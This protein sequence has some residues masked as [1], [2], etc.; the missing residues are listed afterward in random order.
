MAKKKNLSET[1]IIT[2]LIEN[3]Y[4]FQGLNQE[5]LSSFLPPESLTKEKLFSNRPVFTAFLPDENLDSLYIILEGGPVIVRSNPLDR[6][7]SITY[8]GGCFGMRSLPF[9][10]GLASKSFPSLVEA[11]KTTYITKI[12][13]NTLQQIYDRFDIVRDRYAKLFELREKFAYHLLNCSTYPPQAVAALLR[14]LIYQERELQSQPNEKGIYTFDLSVEVIAKACQLNQRTVEQVLKGMQKEGL[15]TLDK[16]N[17][18]SDDIIYILKPEELK[19]VYSST[20]DKVSWW[21]LK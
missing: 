11:Y 6:I 5:E 9:S 10:Y 14:S 18:T 4:L 17:D 13:L 19:E 3:S 16:E 1:S 8:G 15:I 2:S 21:P 20:R 7:I 12:P